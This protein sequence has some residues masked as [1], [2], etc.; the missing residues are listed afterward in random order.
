[1]KSNIF[2]I[3]LITLLI[4]INCFEYIK[5][6]EEDEISLITISRPKALNALNSQVLN[7]LSQILDLIELQKIFL[8]LL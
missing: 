2:Q 7:E 4:S 5:Y 8:L 3:V 1:M 6:T